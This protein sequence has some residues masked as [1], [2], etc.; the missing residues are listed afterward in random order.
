MTQ[1]STLQSFP[2]L[3]VR[4]RFP[5]LQRRYKDKQVVYFDGPG[6][7]QVVDSAIQEITAYMTNGGANLHGFFASSRET[8]QII[9]DARLA[10]A[11]L[12][13]VRPEE[14]AFGANMTTLTLAIARALGRTW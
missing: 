9:A 10:V 7:S 11:D 13:G 5:A 6:G 2:I 12:L 8:E 1:N 4:E 3:Q 14:V